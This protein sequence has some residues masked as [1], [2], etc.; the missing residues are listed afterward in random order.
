MVS[1]TE[2][3]SGF[4]TTTSTVSPSGSMSDILLPLQEGKLH[5]DMTIVATIAAAIVHL[6]FFFIN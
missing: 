6:L 5:I 2:D 1:V 4:P 3:V